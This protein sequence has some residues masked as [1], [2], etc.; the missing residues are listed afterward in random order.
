MI[1][2][3]IFVGCCKQIYVDVSNSD[4]KSSFLTGS[5]VAHS[6][7]NGRPV[8]K[9]YSKYMFYTETDGPKRW[10]VE[11]KIGKTRNENGN[12]IHGDL[13]YE[14]DVSCPEDAGTNWSHITHPFVVD[15]KIT[16]RCGK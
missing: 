5:W 14:G 3:E 12:I 1:I 13:R 9:R 4:T 6:S 2:H 16:V 11:A 10:V 7:F 8:Y 15:G